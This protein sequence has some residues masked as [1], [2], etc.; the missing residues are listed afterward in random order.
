MSQNIEMVE[1]EVKFKSPLIAKIVEEVGRAMSKRPCSLK[2]T[3]RA[4]MLNVVDDVRTA[5]R[6]YVGHIFVPRLAH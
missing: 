5:I 1:N 3:G 6:E 2:L 4:S